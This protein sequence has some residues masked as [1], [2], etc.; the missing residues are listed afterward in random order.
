MSVLTLARHDGPVKVKEAPT[1]APP[2]GGGARD[3]WDA[4]PPPTEEDYGKPEPPPVM[5][6]TELYKREDYTTMNKM[7]QRRPQ[8]P[9]RGNNLQASCLIGDMRSLLPT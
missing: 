6:P 5:F 3:E 1:K 7:T 8:N 2:R 9:S 4:A